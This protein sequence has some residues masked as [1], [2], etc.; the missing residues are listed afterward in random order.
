MSSVEAKALGSQKDRVLEQIQGLA[1]QSLRSSGGIKFGIPSLMGN[2]SSHASQWSA[3]SIISPC[4]GSVKTNEP[5]QTGQT[6][7][8][9][10]F[11]F[12][13]RSYLWMML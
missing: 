7:I 6:M 1:Y 9:K 8:S 12:M 5:L 4:L 2:S 10:S 11:V 3:P 13:S